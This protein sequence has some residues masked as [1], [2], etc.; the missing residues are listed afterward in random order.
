LIRL[1]L[2][3]SRTNRRRKKPIEPDGD[4]IDTQEFPD[5]KQEKQFE[6]KRCD[7]TAA[8]GHLHGY[9]SI[10]GTVKTKKRVNRSSLR[11]ARRGLIS[12][13]SEQIRSY[14]YVFRRYFHKGFA[15]P[16]AAYRMSRPTG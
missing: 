14:V 12:A 7:R 4:C 1:L 9:V 15:L 5:E 3:S 8:S 10:K 13:S 6:S 2:R 11:F 16:G